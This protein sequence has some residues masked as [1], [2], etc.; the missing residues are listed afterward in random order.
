MDFIDKLKQFANRAETM[1]DTLTTEEATKMSL[2]V[3]FFQMLDYDVFNPNEF[4]PEFTADVGI[5]KGEKVDYAILRESQP[6]ILI[7]AKSC[8]EKLEK[9]D[10]QLF[11]YFGTTKAKFAILTNGL[12][13]RFYTDLE[14]PNKMDEKPFLE[15]DILNLKEYHVSELKKFQKN[16]FD[17]EEIFST[18][19]DLKYSN[20]FKTIFSN[21]LQNPSDDLTKLF[22]SH[23]YSGV[24]TQNVIDRF[25][26]VLKKSLNNYINELMNDKIT[27]A[28]NQNNDT[29]SSNNIISNSIDESKV[30]LPVEKSINKEIVTT[31][32]ELEAYFIIKN[33]LKEFVSMDDITYRDTVSYINI[34]YKDNGRKWICRLI[35]TDTQKQLFIPEEDI[36]ENGKKN[37]TKYQ[38]ENIYD[39]E[40]YKNELVTVLKRFL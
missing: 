35:L 13:Y 26:P 31:N 37:A 27:S 28:L 21:E 40:K 30:S 34:L 11:R 1:K 20:E 9:H 38:L 15:I 2:I 5:K 12:I 33:M 24:K 16:N 7:E 25:K 17:I 18:A 4:L 6:I 22:L 14:E 10:S 32:E 36:G 8:N 19:S 3:P 39:I 29:V 23:V